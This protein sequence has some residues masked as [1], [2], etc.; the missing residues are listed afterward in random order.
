MVVDIAFV[1]GTVASCLMNGACCMYQAG[2]VDDL[3]EELRRE[4]QQQGQREVRKQKETEQQQRKD[5]EERHDQ[6]LMRSEDQSYTHRRPR[7]TGSWSSPSSSTQ[8]NSK[9]SDPSTVLQISRSRSSSIMDEVD[10]HE[11]EEE[12]EQEQNG[13]MLISDSILD[14][15]SLG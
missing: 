14:D 11:D 4:W 10:N 9:K 5:F 15:V 7:G 13:L 8:Q 2:R 1:A 3:R 12:A 6:L